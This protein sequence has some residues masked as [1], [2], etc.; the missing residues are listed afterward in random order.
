M[1][2]DNSLKS[3]SQNDVH[4][5]RNGRGQYALSNVS[6]IGND[7]GNNSGQLIVHHNTTYNTSSSS[8]SSGSSSSNGSGSGIEFDNYSQPLFNAR[9]TI[10]HGKMGALA[11]MHS[12]DSYVAR[13]TNSLILTLGLGTIF[14]IFTASITISLVVF[15]KK[16]NSIFALRPPKSPEDE[17]EEELEG[18]GSDFASTTSHNNYQDGDDGFNSYD[19]DEDDYDDDAGNSRSVT[20]YCPDAGSKQN[21][22]ST[23]SKSRLYRSFSG[24]HLEAGVSGGGSYIECNTHDDDSSS[25]QNIDDARQSLMNDETCLYLSVMDDCAQ[26][27]KGGGWDA[28]NSLQRSANIYRS[29]PSS[30]VNAIPFVDDDNQVTV[31]LSPSTRDYQLTSSDTCRHS[32]GFVGRLNLPFESVNTI[33]TQQMELVRAVRRSNTGQLN[34]LI[35]TETSSDFVEPPKICINDI[36][37][38]SIV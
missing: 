27:M 29:L 28:G 33:S 25:N 38:Q 12:R 21:F 36:F 32:D 3:F 34:N 5:N 17:F 13:P 37:V 22:A 19:D 30:D 35:A 11:D 7:T 23:S 31:S 9:M 6:F 1:S 16:R 14:F 8:S 24:N 15:C 10:T 4:L 18:I 20:T 26:Y 2:V